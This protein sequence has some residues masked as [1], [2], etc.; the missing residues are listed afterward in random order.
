MIK[1]DKT[2][3]CIATGPSITEEDIAYV[4]S[5][6]QQYPDDIK[7]VAVNDAWRLFYDS[8]KQSCQLLDHLYAADDT[9]WNTYLEEINQC[10]DRDQIKLWI[11]VKKDFAKK[12]NMNY[13]KL[14]HGKNGLCT[15][16]MA[17][18]SGSHSGYQAINLSYH[19]GAKKIVLL[20]YDMKVKDTSHI[21][22]FGNHPKGLRNS[23]NGYTKWVSHY[24]KLSV[25][26]NRCGLDIINCSRD[27]AI[28]C[29]T[30][31][32][33]QEIELTDNVRNQ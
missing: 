6:K 12:H 13:I 11:P 2:F 19:L 27:T 8:E 21:H 15:E 25:D 17:L 26:A 29:F 4:K 22:Y 14:Y 1:K 31:A 5:M 10:I 20:G 3:I 9:W 28:T 23:P 32:I 24:N 7:I 30:Q 18:Y 16:D 33:I